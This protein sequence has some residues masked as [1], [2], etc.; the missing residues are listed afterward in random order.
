VRSR[1]CRKQNGSGK[2][3]STTWVGIDQNNAANVSKGYSNHCDLA[4]SHA[5]GLTEG[6][7]ILSPLGSGSRNGM[8]GL[9]VRPQVGAFIEVETCEGST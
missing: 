8:K 4:R 7:D 9:I 5:S 2:D 6:K 1:V 3:F